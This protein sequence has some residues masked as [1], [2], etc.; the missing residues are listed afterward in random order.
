M[1]YL[2]GLLR[3]T[4]SSQASH[5]FRIGSLLASAVLLLASICGCVANTDVG[6]ESN[7]L[8][9]DSNPGCRQNSCTCDGGSAL[10]ATQDR[11]SPEDAG[12]CAALQPRD[13]GG[14]RTDGG[15]T[16]AV[17]TPAPHTDASDAVDT[18]TGS[19]AQPR[20]ASLDLQGDTSSPFTRDE[21]SG[22][23]DSSAGRAEPECGYRYAGDWVECYGATE[24]IEGSA[25]T[26]GDC[27]RECNLTPDCVGIQDASWLG[28]KNTSAECRLYLGTT[29]GAEAPPPG[30]TFLYT[31][32]GYEKVCNSSDPGVETVDSWANSQPT[33]GYTAD[34][35]SPCRFEWLGKPTNGDPSFVCED[36]GTLD[37]EISQGQTFAECFASCD[38]DPDCTSVADWGPSSTGD[39]ECVTYEGT[40]GT[41][42]ISNDN[43]YQFVKI[44]EDP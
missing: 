13:G 9:D 21:Q 37:L 28:P 5:A 10:C 2:R 25:L 8:R 15:A 6:G 11:C 3:F 44:C 20:D 26:L 40:C 16:A 43:V 42:R 22:E 30:D 24:L 36:Y 35:N 23:L 19:L 1:R 14:A 31:F 12:Q 7:W 4:S 27:M 34:P 32:M 39:Y 38:Q 29:C 41:P 18:S 17:S 33:S